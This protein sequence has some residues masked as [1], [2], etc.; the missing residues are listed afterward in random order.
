MHDR[1]NKA[2]EPASQEARIA[3]QL[4]FSFD[5]ERMREQSKQSKERDER[6][7][8]RAESQIGIHR[9]A[10]DEEGAQGPLESAQHEEHR[11]VSP[12]ESDLVGAIGSPDRSLRSHSSLLGSRSNDPKGSELN[13]SFESSVHSGTTLG[14]LLCMAIRAGTKAEAKKAEAKKAKKAKNAKKAKRVKKLRRYKATVCWH[15]DWNGNEKYEEDD[16]GEGYWYDAFGRKHQKYRVAAI[17]LS[18]T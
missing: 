6:E 12:T 3:F 10:T 7:R 9:E 1:S 5:F 2:T 14:A 18:E 11:R 4:E 8:A 17:K 16:E 15:E 13:Q